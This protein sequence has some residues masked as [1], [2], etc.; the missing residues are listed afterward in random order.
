MTRKGEGL[1]CAV[2]SQ[3]PEAVCHVDGVQRMAGWG[4]GW[5]V[6]IETTWEEPREQCAAGRGPWPL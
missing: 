2:L 6:W 1:Q 5:G 4:W 3:T